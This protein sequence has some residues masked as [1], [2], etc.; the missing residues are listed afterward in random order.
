MSVPRQCCVPAADGVVVARQVHAWKAPPAPGCE[1]WRTEKKASCAQLSLSHMYGVRN[2]PQWRCPWRVLH[3][4]AWPRC[5][6][7]SSKRKPTSSR[8][9]QF[10]QARRPPCTMGGA[11]DEE[12]ARRCTARLFWARR[13]ADAQS[14]WTYMLKTLGHNA[15]H[16]RPPIWLCILHKRRAA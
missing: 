6:R 5:T 7:T 15:K 2:A 12:P 10:S 4:G 13:R 16:S 11:R 9:L 3:S 1:P 14:L 8:P